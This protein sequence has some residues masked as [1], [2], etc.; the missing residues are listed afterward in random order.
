MNKGAGDKMLTI[1][2]AGFII[3][4]S[5]LLQMNEIFHKKSKQNKSFKFSSNSEALLFYNSHFL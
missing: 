4:F 2:E 5:L 3:L 1:A